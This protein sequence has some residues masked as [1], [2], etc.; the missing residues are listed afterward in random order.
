V[1]KT[2]AIADNS[3]CLCQQTLR[4]E[5]DSGNTELLNRIATAFP[6]ISYPAEVK[7]C[8]DIQINK[9]R[10]K[11]ILSTSTVKL[12]VGLVMYEF[13]LCVACFWQWVILQHYMHEAPLI[14][15]HLV[16]LLE[17]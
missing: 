10:I 5:I 3:A 7:Y 6:W 12:S 4:K 1:P 16:S 15:K 14:K 17:F 9:E 13:Y 8:E 11:S 2:K